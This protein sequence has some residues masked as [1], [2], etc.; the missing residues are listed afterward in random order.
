MNNYF[1][2]EHSKNTPN[3]WPYC[4]LGS[5]TEKVGS[6]ITPKGGERVYKKEGRFFIRSQNV[7]WGKLILNDVKF[8]DDLT[9]SK[10]P[11]TEI[12]TNDVLLNITG[13]S[14]G[15]STIANKTI[16]GGNVNQHVCIIRVKKHI[17]Y[18][19]FLNQVI[20]SNYVQK[21][22]NSFQAGGNR[23][24]INFEQIKHLVVPLPSLAEQKAIAEA[25]SD[26]DELISSLEALIEK[27]KA[28]KQGVMQELLAGK[29]RLPG[30]SG[31]WNKKSIEEIF[32]INT[33][34]SKSRYITEG[35]KY[36]I[37]D[38][39]SIS[40]NGELIPS[41]QTNYSGDFLMIGDLV[42]PKDD[43]GGGKIIGK[44]AYID[45]NDEYV[46]GDHIFILK[47]KFGESRFFHYLINSFEI[48]NR[49]RKKVIGSA[50]LGISKNSIKEEIL[51]FPDLNEQEAISDLIDSLESEINKIYKKTEKIKL[52]K[53]GMMQELL[54]GR[55]RLV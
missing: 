42:M 31:K 33:A 7:G 1:L 27:K 39:G 20:L 34:S 37:I 29:R 4:E 41:K 32:N 18:A 36:L 25:L 5:L 50:Q 23:Q 10:F 43:I 51:T 44:T 13:A 19:N 17:L 14:I 30:F 35:G 9:H 26:V 8:I 38:M 28:I 11:S 49:V 53:Q 15:R 55:I 21:Q 2:Q 12:Q 16:E 47:S 22:I 48:N 52:I 3:R 40:K 45:K 6:G 46:A 54:S 24:G